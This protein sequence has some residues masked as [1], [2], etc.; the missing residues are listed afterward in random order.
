ER[1]GLSDFWALANTSRLRR[2][3]KNYVP[4]ILAAIVIS[5]DPQKF[6]FTSEKEAPLAYDSVPIEGPTELGVVAGLANSTLEQIQD[7]NPALVRLQTPPNYP[8]FELHL[9]AGTRE[10]FSAAYSELPVSARIPW[11]MHTVRAGETLL[12]ISR[13]YGVSE[14]QLRQ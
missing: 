7:L 3:T 10:R 8:D 14:T 12:A 1:T 4:A 5:K 2:E 11:K 6:G 13:R 9:P